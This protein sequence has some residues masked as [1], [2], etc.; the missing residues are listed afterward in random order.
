MRRPTKKEIHDSRKLLRNPYAYLDGDGNYV[1]VPAFSGNRT[2]TGRALGG[3]ARQTG[4][5]PDES[6]RAYSPLALIERRA[7]D[8]QR[9]I[10][11]NAAERWKAEFAGNPVLALD[12]G[13][14]LVHLG[15][16][17]EKRETLG[18]YGN[19]GHLI[20]V[21]GIIDTSVREVNISNQ[22]SP[23]VQRFTAAHE[24][25]HAVL[26]H[27]S[28]LH[29]DRA[30][31]GGSVHQAR[32]GQEWEADKFATFFLMPAKLVRERFRQAFGMDEF[33]LSEDVLFALDP[34]DPEALRRKFDSRRAVSRFLCQAQYFGGRRFLSLA[35]QFLV[36]KDTMAIR[37]EELGIIPD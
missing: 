4:A 24:L 37:L 1:A 32:E 25:G 26:N 28:G 19:G 35:S 30:L 14:A 10:W 3:A 16:R 8:L 2:A 23:E 17:F 22:F 31:D 15:Y 20:E 21:A 29:R 5:L 36:S 12:P 33:V 11:F 6:E 9:D 34:G 18:Q 27:A 7:K 13:R